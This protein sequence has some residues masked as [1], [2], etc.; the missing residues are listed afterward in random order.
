MQPT[1]GRKR[2]Q[3]KK[4]AIRNP[5]FEILSLCSMAHALNFLPGF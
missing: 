1:A 3:G 4:F 5:Q 2:I